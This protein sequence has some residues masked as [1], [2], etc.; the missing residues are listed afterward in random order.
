[1]DT[2]TYYRT[3]FSRNLGI[4]TQAEQD[5]LRRACVAVAGL[6]GVGGL[7]VM[8]LAR[9]GVG[10]FHLADMDVFEPVNINRQYGAKV[11][12]F[13]RPKLDVMVEEALGVNPFLKIVT[14]PEGVTEENLD[15]FLDGVHVVLDGLDFFNFE[16]RRL[17][18]NRARDKGIYVVTAGPLGFS[19]AVLVFSPFEGMSFDEYFDIRPGLND[20]EKVLRFAMGLAP[21]PTHLGYLDMDRVSLAQRSGPSVASACM[22]CAGAAAT[23]AV[24]ILLGRGPVRPVPH[25]VQI[26]P[27]TWTLRR[28]RLWMGNRNPMQ[29]IKEAVIRRFVLTDGPGAPTRT[30]RFLRLLLQRQS[31]FV[32]D[33][34]DCRPR[35]LVPREPV[36]TLPVPEQVLNSLLDAAVQAPSGDNAQPWKFSVKGDTI[37]IQVDPERDRSFFNVDQVA[38]LIACGAAAENIRIAATGFGLDARV[39]VPLNVN[40]ENFHAHLAL[41]PAETAPDPLHDWVWKRHTNRKP[42]ADT[43]LSPLAAASL[44]EA[45]GIFPEARLYL[46]QDRSRI[47]KLA[48]LVYL[49]DRIRSED[50][51]LHEHLHRMIRFSEAEA[52]RTR[53]GF[54]LKNLEAG[55]AGEMFLRLSRP[56]AVMKALNR[57]GMS[58]AVA[59]HAARGMAGAAAAGLLT[60]SGTAPKDFFQGGRALQRI[61]LTATAHRLSFQPMTAVTLF[62][63]RY[64]RQGL[65]SFLPKHHRLLERAF[66]LYQD[67]F[68]QPDFHAT[69][70]VMLF[71]L[72]HAP[73]ISTPTLRRPALVLSSMERSSFSCALAT[74]S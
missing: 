47:K 22:L 5:L 32:D 72:G 59:L 27:Y 71:R 24:K 3:A 62:W 48:H 37:C 13:D 53:D 54:P 70:H 45:A 18:F 36:K 14:L 74:P 63:T 8:T 64:Q 15:R 19:T 25:Y 29:K 44:V 17:L 9:M 52:L 57:L 2:Q 40:E 46:V 41:E 66:A 49:V 39:Q 35:P 65:S 31:I 56:W 20:E 58:R 10:A 16:I 43:R 33:L 69:G 26:D 6:G 50:R 55:R 30:G 34:H 42:F 28:G 23:E 21:R 7:H 12:N 38:S 11:Q 51:R 4:F 73:P 67:L 1:M 61:W 60:V 68:P